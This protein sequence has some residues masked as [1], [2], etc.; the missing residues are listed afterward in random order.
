MRGEFANEFVVASQSLRTAAIKETMEKIKPQ[1]QKQ[2]AVEAAIRAAEERAR[3]KERVIAAQVQ[4]RIEELAADAA[5]Q[6]EAVQAAVRA[7]V[8]ESEER[9]EQRLAAVHQM[10][11]KAAGEQQVQIKELLRETQDHAKQR[12][13][14]AIY[15]AVAEVRDRA[16]EEQKITLEQA[17]EVVQ[18]SA[19]QQAE[20]LDGVLAELAELRA[21]NMRLSSEM[22]AR[23]RDLTEIASM[24]GFYEIEEA[25]V[26][27]AAEAT[28]FTVPT[29]LPGAARGAASDIDGPALTMVSHSDTQSTVLIDAA[30]GREFDRPGGAGNEAF[31]GGGS[32]SDD[33]FDQASSVFSSSNAGLALD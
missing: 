30:Q 13:Q 26:V 3:D 22:E 21:E 8:R 31:N 7:A 14:A 6:P 4:A 12:E 1:L 20:Q 23:T 29:P 11:E 24:A 15:A 32:V 16:A 17:R 5:S 9:A 19:I 10:Y 33:D 28:E 18:M 27:S 25:S 2:E